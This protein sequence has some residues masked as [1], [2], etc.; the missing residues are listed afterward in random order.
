ML[1]RSP[2]LAERC[3]LEA[4]LDVGDGVLAVRLGE[5]QVWPR[6]GH[7]HLEDG[8]RCAVADAAQVDRSLE[9]AD[10]VGTVADVDDLGVTRLL[11]ALGLVGRAVVVGGQRLPVAALEGR[12]VVDGDRLAG[13][14]LVGAPRV[15][16]LRVRDAVGRVRDPPPV[17]ERKLQRTDACRLALVVRRTRGVLP[18]MDVPGDHEVGQRQTDHDESDHARLG[19][20]AHGSLLLPLHVFH[21]TLTWLGLHSEALMIVISYFAIKSNILYVRR[22]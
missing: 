12:H 14:L 20:F 9:G 7:L 16:R 11:A 10:L 19:A 1:R 17:W 13:G 3:V 15:R 2:D 4:L 6:G 8:E 22:G 5:D 21:I 18:V